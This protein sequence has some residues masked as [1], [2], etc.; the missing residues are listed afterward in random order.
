[1][2]VLDVVRTPGGNIG[3]VSKA[4]RG[5]FAISFKTLRVK[6]KT[7]WWVDNEVEFLFNV[8][9]MVEVLDTDT[10]KEL[11]RLRRKENG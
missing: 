10:I 1:M 11:I 8:A 7:A 5:Q 9:D 6:E 3:V 4:E 2:K